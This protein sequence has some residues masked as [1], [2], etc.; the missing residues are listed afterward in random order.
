MLKFSLK[1]IEKAWQGEGEDAIYCS[2]LLQQAVA[3]FACVK[4]VMLF[5]TDDELPI[6]NTVMTEG[7]AFLEKFITDYT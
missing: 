5:N 6:L 1:F 3:M 4:K 7:T 2:E